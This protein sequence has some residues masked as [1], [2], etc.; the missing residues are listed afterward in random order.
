M[1]QWKTE[2]EEREKEAVVIFALAEAEARLERRLQ[3]R[4]PLLEKRDMYC[5]L[6]RD[7]SSVQGLMH[8]RRQHY[9]FKV[10]NAWRCLPTRK[11]ERNHRV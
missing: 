1:K 5:S 10:G 4:P 9:R 3:Q 2:R 7:K 11:R 8:R 6:Q